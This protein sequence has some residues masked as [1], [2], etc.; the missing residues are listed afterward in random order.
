LAEDVVYNRRDK[1]R[2]E[3]GID[4]AFPLQMFS[5]ILYF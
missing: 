3:Y 2:E 4:I 1:W 5:D